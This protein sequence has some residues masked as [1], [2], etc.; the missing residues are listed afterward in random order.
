MIK[1]RNICVVS[2][3]RADYNHL[4]FLMKALKASKEINFKLLVTG[5]H[6]LEEFG[7]TYKEIIEDGFNIDAFIRNKPRKD[8]NNASLDIMSDQLKDIGDKLDTI[9]P[10]IV[11]ILGDRYDILQIAISCHVKNIPIAHFHGGELT[12]GAI[13]DAI[14]HSITKFSD[15]HFV[16]DKVF[17]KRVEQLGE[18]PRN[19]YNIGSLGVLAI[20]A[21]KKISKSDILKKYDIQG[22]YILIALHPE[23]INSDTKSVIE[24][25]FKVLSKQIGRAHV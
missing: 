22:K 23:T 21:T 1:K 8:T 25:L 11:V 14:R 5:M 6:L 4:F 3:C 7:N 18:N 16:A 17:K 10:D 19:I 12:H 24:S 20:K 13:D 9:K 2:S 15:I